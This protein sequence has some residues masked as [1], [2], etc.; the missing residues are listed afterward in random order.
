MSSVADKT[1]R[2]R[3]HRPQPKVETIRTAP[4]RA[5]PVERIE[6][7]DGLEWL[8]RKK[9]MTKRQFSAAMAYRLA[10]RE[11]AAGSLKSFLG[12]PFSG[13]GGGGG[14][15][16]F[17][18]DLNYASFDAQRRLDHFRAALSFGSGMVLMMDGIAGGG[19]SPR[20]LAGGNAKRGIENLTTFL[21][22]CD[23][24]ASLNEQKTP[25]A[26]MAT[27]ARTAA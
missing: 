16:G 1:R 21:L 25:D 3:E 6:D 9:Q 5:A 19:A 26:G 8:W 12:D 27:A 15:S 13:T 2:K 22:A 24:L 17:P 20:G 14:S 7:R 18:P 11:P 23:L 10:Y 4:K